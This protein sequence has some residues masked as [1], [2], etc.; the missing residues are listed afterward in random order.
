V[1]I[2]PKLAYGNINR[3]KTRESALVKARTPFQGREGREH[4]PEMLL[5][6]K[7]EDVREIRYPGKRECG[8]ATTGRRNVRRI[9]EQNGK[10]ATD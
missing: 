5:P 10:A 2:R 9:R 3:I 4:I 7:E 1:R 6:G 8:I